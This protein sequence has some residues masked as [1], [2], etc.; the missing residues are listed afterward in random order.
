LIAKSGEDLRL[1][2]TFPELV[3]HLVP[4]QRVL[5]DDGAVEL[6]VVQGSAAPLLEVITPGVVSAHKGVNLPDTTLPIPALTPRD[7]ELL[8]FGLDEDVDLVAL[9]FVRRADDVLR[10]RQLIAA[11]GGDQLIVAKI[12]KREALE[13][14]DEIVAAS[15]A[16]MV[17]RGDLGVEIPP[18]EVPL[19]QK[20]IVAL[21]RACGKPVI[22]ATQMLQS[23]VA[24]PRPTRAE[25]SDVA[26][27]IVDS[28]DAVMLSGE[29]AVGAY[30]VEAVRTMADIAMTV[31]DE[32]VSGTSPD[33][34]L[35]E[36]AALPSQPA[37]PPPAAGA[38]PATASGPVADAISSGACDV[39]RKIGA[40]AIVTATVSG[41]MG[42]AVA[43]YRAPQPVVAVT[44]RRRT[45]RQLMLSWGVTPLVVD[46]PRDLD[47]GIVDAAARVIEA[48]FAASGDT[49]VITCGMHVFESGGTNLIKAHVLG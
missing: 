4:G 17:A 33:R 24:A 7:E 23:M 31:E 19:W 11:G 34:P 12:E 43:R 48:G 39:A 40:A 47:A 13:A 1:P 3:T 21:A 38:C 18:A 2:V 28:T 37:V 14:I 41:A 36:P 6:V 32:I 25:A 22:T 10:L 29:T 9:S 27:A 35:R 15:D 42:R 16:V 45:A 8:R 46:L 5:I 20:R 26:N 49:V 30:P 44:P